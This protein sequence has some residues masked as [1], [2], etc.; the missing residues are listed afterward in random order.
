MWEFL[1]DQSKYIRKAKADF[2]TSAQKQ[3]ED[4]LIARHRFEISLPFHK[5][6]EG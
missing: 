3:N 5:M 4:S 1:R 6:A 2:E